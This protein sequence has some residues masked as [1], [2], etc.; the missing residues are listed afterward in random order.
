MVKEASNQA[1]EKEKKQVS[2]NLIS[3]LT[4]SQFDQRE[5]LCISEV[6]L[7]HQSLRNA[8]SLLGELWLAIVSAV[9]TEGRRNK[10]RKSRF[11][12]LCIRSLAERLYYTKRNILRALAKGLP[13]AV[14]PL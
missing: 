9:G 11:N 10:M 12:T 1:P 14:L 5:T 8:K 3:C 7:S 13:G 2:I 6:Q 4:H